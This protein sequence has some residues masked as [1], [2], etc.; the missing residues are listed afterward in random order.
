M[1]ESGSWV[2]GNNLTLL[3]KFAVNVVKVGHVSSNDL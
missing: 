2:T 3:Q 1:A